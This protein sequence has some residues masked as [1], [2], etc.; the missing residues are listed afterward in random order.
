MQY[1]PKCETPSRQDFYIS[2]FKWRLLHLKKKTKAP[3]SIRISSQG[4]VEWIE[5]IWRSTLD[6]NIKLSLHNHK[7]W[8]T[9]ETSL[10][11]QPHKAAQW[12]S[13]GVTLKLQHCNHIYAHHKR[14]IFPKLVSTK[15]RRKKSLENKTPRIFHI[16]K[17]NLQR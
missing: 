14:I 8:H 5:E 7:D 6:F 10:F 4:T 1:P 9:R 16:V 15:Q 17:N 11:P 12:F 13:K 3:L 2:T